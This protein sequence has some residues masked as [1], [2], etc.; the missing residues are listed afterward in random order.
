VQNTGNVGQVTVAWPKGISNLYLV[1]SVDDV[2]DTTDTFVPMTTET[3][4]NGVVYN[5]AAVTLNNGEYFTFAGFAQAP[6]GVVDG[7]LMWHEDEDVVIIERQTDIWQNGSGKIRDVSQLNNT[8]YQ[9]S[10]VTHAYYAADRRNYIFNI[11]LFYYFGGSN[12]FFNNT[13]ITT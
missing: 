3:T 2:F 4:V 10:L 12:N 13:E 11:I 1:Q 8:A 6:G 5:T 7:I 9:S